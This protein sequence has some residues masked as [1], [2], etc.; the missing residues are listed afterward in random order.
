MGAVCPLRVRVSDL[1][2]NPMGGAVYV[3][4]FS[5]VGLTMGDYA[6]VAYSAG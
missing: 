1:T 5:E 6:T 4:G 3:T 2:V